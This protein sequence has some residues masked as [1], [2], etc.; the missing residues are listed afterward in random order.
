MDIQK[1][2]IA[3]FL[4]STGQHAALLQNVVWKERHPQMWKCGNVANFLLQNGN[5]ILK[6]VYVAIWSKYFLGGAFLW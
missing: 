1:C 5:P 3:N 6:S 2:G 4:Q